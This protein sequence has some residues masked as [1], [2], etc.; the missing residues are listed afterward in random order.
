MRMDRAAAALETSKTDMSMAQGT[1]NSTQKQH[2][3][4]LNITRTQKRGTNKKEIGIKTFNT[5]E[6]LATQWLKK[7]KSVFILSQKTLLILLCKTRII[8]I[9]KFSAHHHDHIFC[10]QLFSGSHWLS[11]PPAY[12]ADQALSFWSTGTVGLIK[13]SQQYLLPF[14]S[15]T[16]PLSDL[17]IT[18]LATQGQ[19]LAPRA[20]LW[21]YNSDSLPQKC[22]LMPLSVLGPLALR[23]EYSLSLP[24][25]EALEPIMGH[26][27][28]YGKASC[29][30]GHS[31]G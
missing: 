1:K 18:Y 4:R 12:A 26:T 24:L 5:I 8:C 25:S 3:R 31:V 13:G 16:P 6:I 21:S 11:S 23:M 17:M 27:P 14:T 2:K 29:Q 22:H 19:S 7:W 9:N 30:Q 10:K 20:P 15:V 28:L